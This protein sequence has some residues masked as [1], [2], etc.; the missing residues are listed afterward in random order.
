MEPVIGR[1]SVVSKKKSSKCDDAEQSKLFIY[2]A[3][4]IGADED[5]SDAEELLGRLAKEPPKPRQSK[6]K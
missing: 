3:R 5:R 1:V 2:K 4:E 6:D